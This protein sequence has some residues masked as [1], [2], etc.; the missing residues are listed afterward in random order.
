MEGS[1]GVESGAI[2]EDP[3]GCCFSA[4][5]FLRGLIGASVP[6]RGASNAVALEGTPPGG[7]T[8][9]PKLSRSPVCSFRSLPDNGVLGNRVHTTRVLGRET[10]F[11]DCRESSSAFP[12]PPGPGYRRGRRRNE[13]PETGFMPPVVAGPYPWRRPHGQR[14][15][16]RGASRWWLRPTGAMVLCRGRRTDPVGRRTLTTHVS[17]F[18]GRVPWT[19]LIGEI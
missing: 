10:L 9:Q 5:F 1:D 2:R 16:P 17:G 15:R 8:W 6:A 18:W 3:P 7:L 12:C 11:T 13:P 14:G 4:I 19:C